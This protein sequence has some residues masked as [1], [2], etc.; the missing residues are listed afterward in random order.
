MLP[1]CIILSQY[2]ISMK[3]TFKILLIITV[4]VS[5]VSAIPLIRFYFMPEAGPYP[6]NEKIAGSLMGNTGDQFEFIIMGDTHNGFFMCDATTLRIISWINNEDRFKDKYIK[7]PIDFIIH[8]GD[9]TF[10]GKQDSYK[11][12]AKLRSLLKWPVITAVGNH[13]KDISEGDLFQSYCGESEFAFSDRNCYFI[14]IDN[15]EGEFGEN[16]FRWL[17]DRL[18]EGE[19]YEHIFI[20]MHKAPVSPLQRSWYRMETNP[21]HRVFMK[22]CQDYGVDMVITG[23]LHMYSANK[24]SGVEYLTSGAAGMPLEIAYSDGGFLH[25]V[26]VKIDGPYVSYEVRKVAP[27]FWQLITYYIWK[28]LVYYVRGLF[29]HW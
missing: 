27:P 7:C 28:D 12:Y 14:F 5:V 8:T 21:W 13:D 20:V 18:K 3:K 24:F 25:Y 26:V 11:R 4:A 16:K 29:W 9:A 23:H 22:M 2:Y 6:G 19:K 15:A 17:E 1:H 10:R